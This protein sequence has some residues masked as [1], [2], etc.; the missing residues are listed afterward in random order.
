MTSTAW[1]AEP[2]VL[3]LSGLMLWAGLEKL[4][5]GSEF[6]ATLAGV[7]VPRVFTPLL[8][9]GLPAAE[10]AVGTTVA[11]VPSALLPRIGVLILAAA[12]AI[13]GVQGL[14]ATEKIACSCLGGTGDAALGW[15]QIAA[16]PVWAAAVGAVSASHPPANGSDGPTRLAAAVLLMCTVRASTALRLARAARVNRVSFAEG[17]GQPASIF[18]YPQEG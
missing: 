11:L 5:S 17:I 1:F 7:G 10:I 12:F 15:R 6:E 8:R 4:R 2:L 13:A 18:T 14:R 16:L 3:G 9:W